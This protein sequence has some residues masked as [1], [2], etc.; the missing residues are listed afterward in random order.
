V[1][2]SVHY[3]TMHILEMAELREQILYAKRGLDALTKNTQKQVIRCL[4][5]GLGSRDLFLIFR[6]ARVSGTAKIGD[7]GA[8][9]VCGAFDAAF[10]KLLC[11]LVN[12]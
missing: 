7:S 12:L 11:L 10:A 3:G 4:V 2:Y 9:S 5:P 1:K 6:T 8:C